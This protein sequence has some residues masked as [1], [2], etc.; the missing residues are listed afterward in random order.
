MEKRLRFMVEV[1]IPYEITLNESDFMDYGTS[2]INALKDKWA[3]CIKEWTAQDVAYYIERD[4]GA[5]GL[6][7]HFLGAE[8]I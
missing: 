7:A 1:R 3:E 4:P 2:D 8:S 5:C 6:R